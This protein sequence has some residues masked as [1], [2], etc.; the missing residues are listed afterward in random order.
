MQLKVAFGTALEVGYRHVDTAYV[1]QNEEFVGNVLKEWFSTGK[2]KRDD[3]FVTTKLPIM[4]DNP[5]TV[6]D[7]L[8]TSLSRLQL[9]YVDLY[10]IHWPVTGKKD[11]LTGELHQHET[12]HAAIWQ[13]KS[14]Y[15]FKSLRYQNEID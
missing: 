9:E 2:L 15:I 4:S 11:E 1:Y 8:K 12:D 13:V 6:E 3:M 7:Y 14:L 5:N 10:L